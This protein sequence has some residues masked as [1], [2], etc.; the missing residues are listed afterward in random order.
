MILK[1]KKGT[2]GGRSNGLA[3]KQVPAEKK[4]VS[5]LDCTKCLAEHKFTHELYKE[6]NGLKLN[7]WF[8]GHAAKDHLNKILLAEVVLRN[9]GK[10][11]RGMG[12]LWYFL[13]MLYSTAKLQ[14]AT[15]FC[16]LAWLASREE[17][18]SRYHF[19]FVISTETSSALAF[20]LLC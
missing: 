8:R 6:K 14:Y 4:M 1:G 3:E 12:L 18:V 13:P 7:T 15:D 20:G 19:V 17:K 16:G 10:A 11:H 2:H 5:Q 9:Y